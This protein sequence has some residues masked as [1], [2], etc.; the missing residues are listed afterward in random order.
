[1]LGE[2]D[3]DAANL[4]TYVGATSNP[5]E[6]ANHVKMAR[7]F[8]TSPDVVASDPARFKQRAAV[9]DAQGVFDVSPR[10]TGFLAGN[11]RNAQVAHD[12]LGVL[13][14]IETYMR[15][16]TKQRAVEGKALWKFAKSPLL[17]TAA[18]IDSALNDTSPTTLSK[19]AT[20]LDKAGPAAAG[21]A[22][23]AGAID[24]LAGT[25][26]ALAA[27]TGWASRALGMGEPL[28]DASSGLTS[29]ANK[30]MARTGNPIADAA[31]SGVRSIPVSLMSAALAL[32]TRSPGVGAGFAGEVTGG[33]S[34]AEGRRQG[35]SD[36]AA[37]GFGAIDAGL[38][39]G[40]EYLGAKFLVD[41]L[42]PGSGKSFA[43]TFMRQML[44]EVPTE[45]LATLTQ[46]FNQ[47]AFIG[48][49][50][51]KTFGDY[52][53]ERPDAA[54]D[55]LIATVVGT[56]ATTGIVGGFSRAAQ[57]LQKPQDQATDAG[58][59]TELLGATIK[60][61]EAS[62]VRER[63][64]ETFR[65][66]IE[67]MAEGSSAETLFVTPA[68]LDSLAQSGVDLEAALPS[69]F[70]QLAEARATGGDVALPAA[71]F[72]AAA[73]N[74]PAVGEALLDHVKTDP[75]GMTKTEADSFMQSDQAVALQAEV[76]RVLAEDEAGA[77][78]DGAVRAVN[79][80]ILA[81]LEKVGRFVTPVHQKQA[82][83]LTAFYSTLA[84]RLGKPIAE[85]Y[86]QFAI[87][88]AGEGLAGSEAFVEQSN[89]PGEQSAGTNDATG[90]PGGVA[91]AG[92]RAG[93]LSA[94]ARGAGGFRRGSGPLAGASGEGAVGGRSGGSSPLP[95]A[96]T[97]VNGGRYGRVAST[98][99]AVARRTAERYAA[100]AGLIFA[101]PGEYAAVDGERAARIAAEYEA[102]QH[103]P[104]DPEV[105]AAYDAMIAETLAQYQA[106]K[107]TG[108]QVDFITGDNPY[109]VPYEA[110]LDVR[111]NNHLWVFPT[112]DGFG[113]SFT[114]A[115]VLDNP[116][117]ALTDETISGKPARANDIF[118]VVHDYF[119]HIKDGNGF[120][121]TGEENAWQSHVKMYS[122]LAARAM[123]SETR[124]QN[125]WVNFGP[126][127]EANRADPQNTTYAEQKIGLLPEWVMT[128]GQVSATSDSYEQGQTDDESRGDR[129][130]RVR[131]LSGAERGARLEA[132]PVNPDGTVTL[133]HFGA[134]GLT[135]T[136]PAKWGQSASLS[137]SAR[138]SMRG[139][140]ARTYFGIATGQRGGY[141]NEF[142]PGTPSY[143]ARVPFERL[144]DISADPDGIYAPNVFESRVKAAGYAGYWVANEELGLVA[145]VFEPVKVTPIDFTMP[146]EL[147][148]YVS[149]DGRQTST[150][151]TE[152]DPI[153]ATVEGVAEFW[154]WYRSQPV[155]AS[156]ARFPAN[157][158]V[159]AWVDAVEPSDALYQSNY[160]FYS[161][162]EKAVV[163]SKTAKAPP[164]QWKATLAKTP[165][166]K[167]EEVEWTGLNDW[168]DAQAEEGV[169]TLD[170]DA[171]LAF[172]RNNGV[173]IEEITLSDDYE[174]LESSG[175][176]ELVDEARSQAESDAFDS[177]WRGAEVEEETE[178]DYEEVETGET[179][180]FGDPI[181]EE[182][183]VSV[184][185]YTL[186]IPDEF[187]R[188][189]IETGPFDTREEAD[190]ALDAAREVAFDYAMDRDYYSDSSY[191]AGREQFG[192]KWDQYKVEGGEGYFEL[193]LR[194]PAELGGNPKKSPGTHWDQPGVV[195]HVR[196]DKRSG[197]NGDV[198]VI[199]EIQSDW[200]AAGAKQGY[201][202]ALKSEELAAFEARLN[203]INSRII[204][205]EIAP[206]YEAWKV[207]NHRAMSEA[208]KTDARVREIDSRLQRSRYEFRTIRAL[209]QNAEGLIDLAGVISEP[210]EI[211][212]LVRG[213]QNN[214]Q[215]GDQE[216]AT[217]ETREFLAAMFLEYTYALAAQRKTNE[218]VRENNKQRPNVQ[219]LLALND[220]RNSIHTK[221]SG[222]SGVADAP[223]KGMG[224]AA[225]AMKRIIRWAAD[226]D[227]DSVAWIRPEQYNG[228]QTGGDDRGAWFYDRNLVNITNDILK[229]YRRK[230]E[231]D[232]SAVE[233]PTIDAAIE[234]HEALA[235]E[236][237]AKLAA[238]DGYA[239][240]RTW[241]QE[242]MPKVA[243]RI[244]ELD[245]IMAENRPDQSTLGQ[246]PNGG[247]VFN[248]A[249]TAADV[250]KQGLLATVRAHAETLK[251]GDNIE[252]DAKNIR[253][254][255]A[256]MKAYQAAQIEA[257]R[258]Q[259][260]N[261]GRVYRIEGI[262]GMEGDETDKQSQ[263]DQLL[264]DI[265]DAEQAVASAEEMLAGIKAG[266]PD[267]STN[268]GSGDPQEVQAQRSLG[269]AKEQLAKERAEIAKLEAADA[270]LGFDITPE[271]KEGAS[272]GFAL[273]QRN[274][275]AY[276]P[277][278]NT[279]TLN[280][281]SDLSTFLH[282]TA[283]AFLEIYMQVA[284][285]PGAPQ[286]IT[287]DM[288]A[289]LRFAKVK[290]LAAW[291]GMTLA[292]QRDAHERFARGFEKRLMSGR[293]PSLA[294]DNLFRTFR[295]WLVSVYKKMK[296]LDV[297]LSP[298]IIG[299][300]DRMIAT[301]EEI[302]EAQAAR[303][304]LPLFAD[305]AASGMTTGEWR[306]Y[307]AA[308]A[309][310]TGDAAT[311]L[312][313]RSLRD[314]RWLTNARSRELAKLQRQAARVRNKVKAEVTAEVMARPVNQA[315]T[316]LKRGTINGEPVE[317]G[318]KLSIPEV[319]AMLGDAPAAAATKAKLG[320]GKYGM[321]GAENGVH[322]QQ[323]AE[324]FGFKDGDALVRELVNAP[325][326]KVEIEGLTEQRLLEEYGDLT[327]PEAIERAADKAV[328]NEA[329]G[330]A[331][332]A[333]LAALSKATGSRK[334]LGQAA[335]SFAR[336]TIDRLKVRDLK[337]A[338]YAAAETRAAKAAMEAL[339]KG[340]LA[341]A[342]SEKRNQLINFYAA[343]AAMEAGG[344]IERAL[345]YFGK[346]DRDG[347]RKKI[348]PD[349]R[350]Q[351]DQLLERFDLRK[352]QSLKA[353]DKRK[354]LVDWVE[355]QRELGFEPVIPPALLEEAGRVS[356][357][358]MTVE[359]VRGL[360]D[361]IKNIEHLGRL[362]TRL[363]TAKRERDFQKA[364]DLAEDT[365][366]L[367]AVRE[368]KAAIE[369]NQWID[370]AKGATASFFA[371][372]RKLAS[373]I[374][375][376]DGFKH[377]PLWDMIVRPMNEAGD[378][379]AKMRAEAT[380]ALSKILAPIT[381]GGLRKKLFI[382]E[383]NNSLSLEGRLAIAL[384]SGNETNR[385]RI[386]EGDRWNA[387]QVDAILATLTAEQWGII[388]E[389]WDYVDSYW[390]LVAAK[391]RRVSGV[392][393]EKVE[394]TPFS[395]VTADGKTLDFAG[396]YYPIK[397]DPGRSTK[398]ESDS[399]AEVTRQAMQGLYTRATTRRGHTQA[400]VESVKR[401][402]RKDLGVLFQHVT[403]VIHDLA[404]HEWLID[405]NRLLRAGQIDAAIRDHYGPE[406]LKAM[407]DAVTDIAVGETPAANVF[408]AG[409]N[410]LRTG[411]TVAGLGW[412]LMTSLLQPLGLSNSI[413]TIGP[414][415]VGIGIT[416]A[417]KDAASLNASTTWIKQ[418]STFM[419]G[420]ADTQQ[421]EISEI[422]N[423]VAREQNRVLTAIED[424]FF[425]LISRAQLIA[426]VP[427]W[428]G[429]YEKAMAD[430][431]NLDSNGNPDEER[432]VSLADQSVLDSQGGGQVKDLAQVQRGGPL[433]KL[434]TNFYS[435]MNLTY[436]Q[437]AEE[438]GEMKL[439][440]AKQLPYFLMDVALIS[441]IPTTLAFFMRQALTGGDDDDDEA[442][443]KK[444]AKENLGFFL[445]TMIG[446]RELGS[447]LT[448]DYRYSSPAGL[449]FLT[450]IS[451]L[452]TQ[453]EQGEA[454]EAL[455]KALNNT[456]G[457]II[458][459]PAGQVQRTVLGYQALANGDTQNPLVLLTGPTRKAG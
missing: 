211:A 408:E 247:L 38:E 126:V 345:A 212:E 53:A 145:V 267:Y 213:Y 90:T 322:P 166:V 319:D 317:G 172:V 445:G 203:D 68:A 187:E 342:A 114:D 2:T 162:L 150:V 307:Q 313:A 280:A 287:N 168:F 229:P 281:N 338:R 357:K 97:T 370:K 369:S 67:A 27:P 349:Y 9:D 86:E 271:I 167:K 233:V 374:R 128:E 65:Q 305:E 218:A 250:E 1:M 432:A 47:W 117:L 135:E 39:V 56:G 455:W 16:L 402:V 423:K 351:I 240:A 382:P 348:D 160:G 132:P 397:Y 10:L 78:T 110:I 130:I 419:A 88:F 37:I 196:A 194:L 459:Y 290:D 284:N 297:T 306:A 185:R 427:T 12:D 422:R 328:H 295:S 24:I 418:R 412:N 70:E 91:G 133:T 136:D 434:F 299:V 245:K 410:H 177:D 449:R 353:I 13:G 343:K 372:H 62:K 64:P 109:S 221:M 270:N 80:D 115:D 113:I 262:D 181:T 227:F 358:D 11:P 106:I 152:E 189:D 82:T 178:T 376:M 248:D 127:G 230:G 49:N 301:D 123:T 385:L 436:N 312:E 99:D 401:P 387:T 28:L 443:A 377:G 220:E 277:S 15:N 173:Q 195:A 144:Y 210:G 107:A 311:E 51:G 275:G 79:D 5:D 207:I 174:V 292:Q 42:A 89:T 276:T 228:G 442:L 256:N 111:E 85:V 215:Q 118:R 242:E 52:L 25:A 386:M 234:A 73:A 249:F 158:D 414:K 134:E 314:M 373:L 3:R 424:S 304:M 329:R 103:A 208:E 179:D 20:A 388:Q 444:L 243:A 361:T 155:P 253:T 157:A 139:S 146:P 450:E 58:E 416:R 81:R 272:N 426:D 238:L 32:G 120:G 159:D 393:P 169:K 346:F 72:I 286:S 14:G 237:E 50:Q 273:F 282:E 448:R 252:A 54:R 425:Y 216:T 147:P 241:A 263:I 102:M 142:A 390:P 34:Y 446:V 435:Y 355:R 35:L 244:T 335:R 293:S 288:L 332:S 405:A 440:G 209:R 441:F 413:R 428:I 320:Y 137:K 340:N 350:D 151:T 8:G 300:M 197:P 391:E 23:G 87:K 257:A 140:P 339:A 129:S 352:G 316:F 415:W 61:A 165:G 94:D 161:A 318:F 456:A 310:A 92:A 57:A 411:V 331:I 143:E 362:K 417:L 396:G 433:M 368:V 83:Y 125:S 264:E 219:E 112:D 437:L 223:F 21:R 236:Q 182:R 192:S 431:A 438:T 156:G 60:M 69:A 74:D 254:T 336:Q 398:A 421:R 334:T 403:E 105:R 75:F 274:R 26:G 407:R 321:L 41:D 225:L 261:A 84:Q 283:H 251:T 457:I 269:A 190:E 170:R 347:V 325:D 367:N 206:E 383:I 226:N 268:D 119:G 108:L 363:L 116:L 186:R 66:A 285:S 246:G 326:P 153:A 392:E 451:K 101:R 364:V 149:I 371:M 22:L 205:I 333:E 154:A 148:R 141:K 454:D 48:Q 430:P 291:N 198:L 163:D 93:E 164:A 171:V 389:V 18:A 235:A 354:S 399:L 453:I 55:T 36:P 365:I 260:A 188:A 59:F 71:E 204:D 201:N 4:Y 341:A 45:Q 400:R 224:Y 356:F 44:I 265:E 104:Q 183:A 98:G 279:I 232:E 258:R 121:P 43:R 180:L 122:P 19:T 202:T 429:A 337:P 324:L 439:K 278:T 360:V 191:D 395:V 100:D 131:G 394:R 40:T 200:H 222:S 138:S 303:S 239:E 31:L 294:L 95:G 379:E 259:H 77:K 302:A 255:A 323:V 193:L 17:G 176:Q 409:V 96:P 327:S 231:F 29:T 33:L 384:N 296:N 6:A 266:D 380:V 76:D 375:T 199:H 452:K 315:A 420:R 124:G 7:R 175:T 30:L 447:I 63:D 458:H 366:R 404:W 359:E 217:P 308:T 378:T 381:A 46:D 184:T 406:V 344:D 289:F 330:R 214:P 309:D 298:E